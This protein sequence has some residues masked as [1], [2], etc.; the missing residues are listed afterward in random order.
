MLRTTFVSVVDERGL[1]V[2]G[3]TAGEFRAELRGKLARIVSARED[4][5]PRRVLLLLDTGAN[6]RETSSGKWQLA[7]EIATHVV[8]NSPSTNDLRFGIFGKSDKSGIHPTAGEPITRPASFEELMSGLPLVDRAIQRPPLF[9]VMADGVRLLEKPRP[10][11]VIFVVTDGQNDSSKIKLGELE[12][13]FLTAG[14]RIFAVTLP[15]RYE[16]SGLTVNAPAFSEERENTDFINFTSTTGG[17]F[18][19]VLPKFYPNEWGFHFDDKERLALAT[20]LQ[21]LYLQ[22]AHFYQLEVVLPQVVEKSCP[23]EVAVMGPDGKTRKSLRL[24]HPQKL[25]PC[26]APSGK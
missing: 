23:L 2:R 11:D 7:L 24:I 22:M 25:E 12:H 4:L 3:L 15:M 19:R 5:N 18:F 1:P 6:M 10:G 21:L 20:A 17:K 13:L 9:D 8:Q 14:V 26:T 16:R